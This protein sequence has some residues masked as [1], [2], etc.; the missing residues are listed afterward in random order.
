MGCIVNA[1]PQLHYPQGRAPVST[2]EED[3]WAQGQSGWVQRTETFLASPGFKPWIIQPVASRYTDYIILAPKDPTG[4]K[5]VN[6]SAYYIARNCDTYIDNVALLRSRIPGT[7]NGPTTYLGCMWLPEPFI[8]FSRSP[9]NLSTSP[10]YPS[11]VFSNATI[12]DLCCCC[13]EFNTTG[14][15]AVKS[16][17]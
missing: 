3:G 6:D 16:F 11:T 17:S 15:V 12:R 13:C 1:T 8:V 5:E 4:E 10:R 9:S 2:V 7:N 14:E